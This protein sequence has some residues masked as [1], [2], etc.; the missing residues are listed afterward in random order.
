MKLNNDGLVSA[1]NG[2]AESSESKESRVSWTAEEVRM[3]RYRMGWSRAE[4]ARTLECDLAH[5]HEWERGRRLPDESQCRKLTQF[6]HQ[7][8][9]NADSVSR[10]PVAEA[11]MNDRN[12]SQIHESEVI[13][14]LANGL[15]KSFSFKP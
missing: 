4:L 6:Q 15:L 13:D 1:G 9:Q 7:A 10:R 8:E 2:G 12:L 14:C 11:L 3:L 5:V